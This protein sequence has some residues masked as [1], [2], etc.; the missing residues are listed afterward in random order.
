MSKLPVTIKVIARQLKLSIS[1]VSRALQNHP[2]IGLRTRERVQALAQRLQYIPNQNALSL[3]TNRRYTLG[4]ILPDLLNPFFIQALEG[5]EEIATERGYLLTI[6]P[7]HEKVNDEK[8]AVRLL[9]HSR[10]DGLLIA[11]ARTTTTYE[12][13]HE[14][15]ALEVPFVLMDRP[16]TEVKAPSVTCDSRAG[17]EALTNFLI[18]K[19]F[20]R[21]AHLQGPAELEASGE[22]REGFLRA[23]NRHGLPVEAGYIQT[24]DLTTPTTE[25]ATRVLLALQPRPEAIVAFNDYTALDAGR[26]ARALG[27]RINQDLALVSFGNHPM[28]AYLDCPPLATIEQ[29]A[30]AMGA[31]ATGLLLRLIESPAVAHPPDHIRLRPQLVIN[32][33]REALMAG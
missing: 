20:R 19:G 8:R 30:Y 6:C 11:V 7:S 1:T 23:M 22:R 13:L 9:T 28:N 4:V 2:S 5:I 10:V 3:K 27:L 16:V 14:L 29:H 21:I 32:E 17:A 12:H 25:R 33:P 18:E 26:V 24:T 31:Q 15:T